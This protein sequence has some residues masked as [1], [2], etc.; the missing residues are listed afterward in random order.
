LCSL[1]QNKNITHRSAPHYTLSPP[2]KTALPFHQIA[3]GSQHWTTPTDPHDYSVLTIVRTTGAAPE[4]AV[5]LPCATTINGPGGRSVLSSTTYNRWFGLPSQI[6]STCSL[7]QQLRRVRG[8]CPVEAA[9]R[10]SNRRPVAIRVSS[11]RQ[12]CAPHPRTRATI[13]ARRAGR[14]G[15]R[16][17]LGLRTWWPAFIHAL[18]QRRCAPAGS[19]Q[20]AARTCRTPHD[21]RLDTHSLP[22]CL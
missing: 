13:K 19:R 14:R 12:W 1:Q 11:R 18:R 9:S 22:L 10:C 4:R 21:L 16:V 6:S 7:I 5:F 15:G 20:A 17:D 2:R 3:T 8:L